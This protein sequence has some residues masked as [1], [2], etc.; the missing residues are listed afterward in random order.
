LSQAQSYANHVRIVPG[1]HYGV[2]GIFA[3]NLLWSLGRLWR[4]PG[5]ESALAALVAL[6]LLAFSAMSES[7]RPKAFGPLP[8]IGRPPGGVP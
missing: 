3:L 2:L 8:K 1:F 5:I 6:A 4:A 7:M